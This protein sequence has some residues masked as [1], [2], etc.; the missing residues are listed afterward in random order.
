MG[1]QQRKARRLAG[2]LN[3]GFGLVLTIATFF[4][5]LLGV[6]DLAFATFMLS[7]NVLLMIGGI[8]FVL[9]R[10]WSRFV[11][12]PTSVL[13]LGGFPVGTLL[14]GYTMLALYTTRDWT[15]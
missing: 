11:L 9:G 15:D 6:W 1:D 5:V 4:S 2:G 8:A 12:W 3:A 14:G 10:R 7:L 13:M